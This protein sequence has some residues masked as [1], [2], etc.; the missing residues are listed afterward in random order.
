MS[1]NGQPRMPRMRHLEKQ[2][3]PFNGIV[4]RMLSAAITFGG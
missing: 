1:N 4:N 2:L 3:R